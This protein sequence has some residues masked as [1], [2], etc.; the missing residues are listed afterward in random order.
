[1]AEMQGKAGDFRYLDRVQATRVVLLVVPFHRFFAGWSR[2]RLAHSILLPPYQVFVL[3]GAAQLTVF[4]QSI[5]ARPVEIVGQVREMHDIFRRL[6][7]RRPVFM[8][9]FA[10][11][12]P[13]LQENRV[14]REL[15]GIFQSGNACPHQMPASGRDTIAVVSGDGR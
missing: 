5:L 3:R 6:T 7:A 15:A 14:H 13:D 9:D 10:A 1:M 11:H 12:R 8:G 2:H 4:R